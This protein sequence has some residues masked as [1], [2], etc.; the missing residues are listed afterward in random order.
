MIGAIDIGGTKIA[1]GV[2]GEEGRVISRLECPTLPERGFEDGFL[3]MT[4]MLREAA[5]RAGGE[6]TGLGIGCT[7]PVYPVRGVVGNVPFLPGW[8]GARLVELFSSEFAASVVMEN[9]A[10]AAVLAEAHWGIGRNLDRLIYVTVGTGIGGGIILD[11]RL[12][13]GVDGSH[14]EIGHQVLDPT[15]PECSCGARGCWES[16]ASGPAMAAWVKSKTSHNALSAE[17]LTAADVCCMAERGD[18]LAQR[19]V[20]RESHYLGLGLANLITLFCPDAIVLGGGL[21]KIAH[22]FL[23]RAKEVISHTCGYVPHHKVLVSTASHGSDT[24][25]IGAACVW[26][27]RFDQK[28]AANK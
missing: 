27:N 10:D 19:A 11:G 5:T 25:L 3:R 8:E 16:I 13:R 15:G 28:S 18:T 2:V 26:H 7:G 17:S 14:P 24:A 1:V 12:Y 21:M 22:L 23:E 4:Q 20:E 6:I 9:D